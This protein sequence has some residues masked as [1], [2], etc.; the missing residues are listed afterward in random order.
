MSVGHSDL[1]HRLVLFPSFPTRVYALG[2]WTLGK[3]LVPD[4]AG[5]RSACVTP[6]KSH[7]S[8]AQ[9]GQPTMGLIFAILNFGGWGFRGASAHLFACWLRVVKIKTQ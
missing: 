7:M 3:L 1:A 4:H 2:F 8:A 5:R 9:M 6:D